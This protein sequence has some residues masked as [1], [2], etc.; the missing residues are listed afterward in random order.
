MTD[1]LELV[2]ELV[3]ISS[4]SH[5]EVRIADHVER[6]L[7]GL[8]GLEVL[9]I[10][11]NVVARTALGREHRLV[12]AGHLDTVPAAGN[13]RSRTEGDVVHGLGSADMKGGLAVMLELAR[14]AA[15]AALDTTYVFYACE[16]VATRHSGLKVLER[17]RPDLLGADAAIL[18]EP[19]G[20]LVEAGCQG[21][22]RMVATLRG[23]RSHSARPWAGVNA[24]HRLAPLLDAVADFDERRPV[25]DGCE[26][27]ESL[28][29]VGVSGGVAGNVVPDE[30]RVALS[31]RFAPDRHAGAAFAA[32]EAFLDTAL[33]TEH[34][35]TLELEDSAPAAAP[36]LGHP[37]L[38]GL[39]AASGQPA[40]AKIGWT[41]VAFFA[42]RGVP[43]ANFGPGDPLV[44]H[45]PDEFV[46]R[47]DLVAVHAVLAGVIG[48]DA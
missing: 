40:R 15:D 9:R 42:A 29:A 26:F 25:I 32:I 45:R 46:A 18:L 22:L 7:R 43:A 30:A 16:E 1:L 12:L 20:A 34:G 8:P 36:M 39:V 21:V 35:D 33:E 11:H 27:H 44:A 5:D 19:T 47:S 4:V 48:R 24:I 17:E 13:A 6:V 2:A 10:E 14:T 37:L 23:R 28:Q 38:A 31:H 3:D 41:D